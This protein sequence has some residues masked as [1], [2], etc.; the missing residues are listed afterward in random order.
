MSEPTF[1]FL[2][3]DRIV[4]LLR[5]ATK[6]IIYAAPNLSDKIANQL[7][8]FSVIDE[9]VSLRIIIDAD[10]ESFRLGFGEFEGLKT[11]ADAKI[12]VRNAPGL[13]IGVLVIDTR[14]WVFSPTPEIIFD[15]PDDSTFNAVEVSSDFA[16]QILVSLAPELSVD[17]NDPISAVVIPD[18]RRPEI[19]VGVVTKRTIT[20]IEQELKE[21]PPQKFDA[22]RQIRVYQNHFQFVDIKLEKC[23]LGSH[24]IKIPPDLLKLV[25]DGK[26][27]DRIKASYKLLDSACPLL[28]EFEG[29]SESVESLRLEF[30][31]S[32]GNSIGR[33]IAKAAREKFDQRVEEVEVALEKLRA[34]VLARL[35]A[36]IE[37]N[38]ESLA[39]QL[40]D[41]VRLNPPPKLKKRL[42]HREGDAASAREFIIGEI[43]PS[44]SKIKS[45]VNGM[46]LHCFFKDIT[47]ETLKDEEFVK[48]VCDKY[49]K[50]A[51]IHSELDAIEQR[52]SGL[53]DGRE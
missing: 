21:A 1:T 18:S 4:E 8:F 31:D 51:T 52:K 41:D 14:A 15:Q 3:N 30:T 7:L 25:K 23:N 29:I 19:G 27:R 20:A 38:C 45:L 13:R 16:Q 39:D 35:T 9:E 49:P 2:S 5:T 10:A 33:I 12:D 48:S 43:F 46:K 26:V 11:L 17:K 42:F 22:A 32:V 44:D 37:K 24:T 40:V 53:P 28:A 50:I 34:N 36:E 47:Y 6:R